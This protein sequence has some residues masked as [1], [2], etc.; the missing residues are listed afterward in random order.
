M[1]LPSYIAS[2]PEE[3]L[4]QA[5]KDIQ[6]M[7]YGD[8]VNSATAVLGKIHKIPVGSY[9]ALANII[10]CTLIGALK[11]ED[12]V[13]AIVDIL[14]LSQDEA[15]NV[16]LDMEKSILEKARIKVIGKSNA[17]MVT[18]SFPEGRSPDELRKEI[19]D[20]TKRDVSITNL[21]IPQNAT[22]LMKGGEAPTGS[23]TKLLEQLQILDTI[24][25]DKEIE[26][27]LKK[28]QEQISNMKTDTSRDLVSNVPL[29]EFMSNMGETGVVNASLKPAS[30]SK[31]PVQY[32]VDPYREVSES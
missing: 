13:R 11:P 5:P 2:N 10:S 23:R 1:S 14:G 30:Y 24:P 29:Q 18:L 16:A 20:T 15:Q 9:V 7:I 19:L 31:A 22:V 4:D 6:E 27:R 12:V 26:E 25:D 8:A 21:Q 3:L 17:D 28:I 32:N